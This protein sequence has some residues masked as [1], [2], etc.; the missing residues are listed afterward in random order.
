MWMDIGFT[1]GSRYK[2]QLY[3][4]DYDRVG[5]LDVLEGKEQCLTAWTD[6]KRKIENDKH[7]AKFA[8]IK[9]VCISVTT[10]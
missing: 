7:P 10:P 8:R 2:F 3:I 4:D 6:L 1:A 9:T 5:Y